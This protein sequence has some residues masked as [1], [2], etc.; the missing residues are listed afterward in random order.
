MTRKEFLKLM[1]RGRKLRLA[2]RKK[3][4][5]MIQVTAEQLRFRVR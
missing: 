2:A 4:L 3:L 5:G 1:A